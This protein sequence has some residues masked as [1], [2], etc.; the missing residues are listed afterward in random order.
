[1]RG[2][3]YRLKTPTLAIVVRDGQNAPI[4]IPSGAEIEV[5]NG[6][7][8]GNR[9]LDVAWEGKTV[10][11]FTTDIRERGERLDGAGS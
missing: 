4:T 9:L 6:P 3:R 11:M 2:Q 8:D 7:L 10:M 1:M 5:V